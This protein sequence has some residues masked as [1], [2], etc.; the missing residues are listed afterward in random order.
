MASRCAASSSSV[1][2]SLS[3]EVSADAAAVSASM[4]RCSILTSAAAFSAAIARASAAAALSP[5]S[6]ALAFSVASSAALAACAESCS[7]AAKSCWAAT[8]AP[9]SASAC[10]SCSRA[11][12]ARAAESSAARSACCWRRSSASVT[13]WPS[14]RSLSS[15]SF[16]IATAVS[17]A[18]S[19]SFSR[20][21]TYRASAR[22]A[23]DSSFS[24]S[25]ANCET[26]PASC[27]RDEKTISPPS[28]SLK[29]SSASRSA[30]NERKSPCSSRSVAVVRLA[31]ASTSIGASAPTSSPPSPSTTI[32]SF[33]PGA[34][35]GAMYL[36]VRSPM[37]LAFGR[38]SGSTFPCRFLTVHPPL[39]QLSF[40]CS[41]A[42]TKLPTKTV[43]TWAGVASVSGGASGGSCIRHTA[44]RLENCA[45][46]GGGRANGASASATALAMK[47][48][49]DARRSTGQH[50]P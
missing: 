41:A 37:S 35:A 1:A 15:T 34:P 25:Y 43:N 26:R 48:M 50:T 33:G 13:D 36:S 16:R 39:I 32:G 49:S 7:C 28:V 45:A 27:S 17:S 42:S 10:A 18:A 19:S 14:L 11:I 46:R 21:S 47:I 24:L 38:I 12:A 23:A 31:V 4:S 22:A 29:T 2:W 30:R 5:S 3:W 6:A 8:S 44:D 40:A 9:R 20:S